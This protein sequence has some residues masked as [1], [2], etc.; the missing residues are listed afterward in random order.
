MRYDNLKIFAPGKL[1]LMGEYAVRH[2]GPGVVM[3]IDRLASLRWL[4]SSGDGRDDLVSQAR[5]HTAPLLGVGKLGPCAVD[6]SGFYH[7]GQKLGLGSSAAVTAASVASVFVEAGR[8]I[9][10]AI[11]RQEMW[12]IAMDVHD[13]FQA[14]HGSG[15]DL[16]AS[17]FGGF[18]MMDKSCD[19]VPLK[20]WKLPKGIDLLFCWTHSPASTSSMVDAIDRWSVAHE[21]KYAGIMSEMTDLAGTFCHADPDVGQTIALIDRYGM[22]MD[23]LGRD[24]GV[25]VVTDMMRELFSL[26]RDMGGAAK[27]SGAGGG[28][29]FMAAFG[30]LDARDRFEAAASELGAL[31]VHF[32]ICDKGVYAHDGD[33][34]SG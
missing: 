24:S 16:A 14:V 10:S 1:I 26:A 9:S 30:D 4:S 19:D 22:L 32:N 12:D 7:E 21:T 23:R 8:D 33:H 18:V 29:F 28:D 2:D 5:S 27:P 3:A 15:L 11:E 25:P 13:R 34:H 6:S 20:S 17:I 31:P